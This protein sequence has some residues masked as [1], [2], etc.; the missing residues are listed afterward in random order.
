[1]ILFIVCYYVTS[2]QD[3]M[4]HLPI[5]QYVLPLKVTIPLMD[6]ALECISTT[7]GTHHQQY[8]LA[9]SQP[10]KA[11]VRYVHGCGGVVIGVVHS[12]SVHPSF[13]LVVFIYS[14]HFP[15]YFLSADM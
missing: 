2:N 5:V 12:V 11:G 14:F 3:C 7:S 13:T 15:C 6:I 1:M 4:T 10:A 8:V 9:A